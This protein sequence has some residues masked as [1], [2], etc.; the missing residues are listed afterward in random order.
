M[1]KL[2]SLWK[3]E[4]YFFFLIVF[5]S[6]LPIISSKYFPTIDG[7]AH[8]HN[9]N[10]LRHIW[11]EGNTNLLQFFDFN[12]ELNSNLVNHVWF[13]FGGL[14]L[15]SHLVEKSILVFYVIALPFS[16]RYLIRNI[17]DSE[18]SGKV[19]SYLI[20]PLIYSFPFCIGFF[21]FCI[22]IPIILWCLGLWYKNKNN[23]SNKK[24]N[25]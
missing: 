11:F 6:L 17:V 7:P 8:L 25:T 20:F 5:I 18:N 15:P 16:F 2:N 14:F 1:K 21:N 24:L 23:P 22:G 12:K 3:Y 10:L 9:A 13:A 4:K 19:S